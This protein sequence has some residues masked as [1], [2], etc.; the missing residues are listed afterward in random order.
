MPDFKTN[1]KDGALTYLGLYDRL[2]QKE[3]VDKVE[4]ATHPAEVIQHLLR[5]T[6]SIIFGQCVLVHLIRCNKLRTLRVT[7]PISAWA[8]VLPKHTAH[9]WQ[10]EC[11]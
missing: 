8:L 3:G 10:H 9:Q 11:T 4:Q 1:V 2:F 7:G 5:L 6:K